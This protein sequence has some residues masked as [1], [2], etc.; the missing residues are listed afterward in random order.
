MRN[1]IQKDFIQNHYWGVINSY[2]QVFFS[3]DSILAYLLLLTTFIDPYVGLSGVFSILVG[4]IFVQWLGFPTHLVKDGTYGYNTLMIGLVLGVYYQFSIPFFVV[5]TLSCFF[6]VLLTIW[7]GNKASQQGVPF[8]SLPFLLTIWITILACRNYDALGLSTRGIY[9]INELWSFG[10]QHLVDFNQWMNTLPIPLFIDTYLKSLG[11]IF[12]QYNALSGLLICIG[13]LYASRISFSLSLLGFTVGY[14]FY[15]FLEGNITDLHY[16]YIGF[17]FILCAISLGGFFTIPSKKS[18]LLIIILTPIIAL[19]ISALGQVFGQLQLPL[20]SLPFNLIVILSIYILRLR[21]HTNGLDLIQEQSFSPEKNLYKFVN[22]KE[23]FA[24]D[25]YVHIHPPFFGKWFISQ[26]YNGGITH[27]GEWQDALDFVVVQENNQT[28][29]DPGLDVNHFHC[30][31]LPVLAPA[32]GTVVK[33]E[34]DIEDNPIGGVNLVKN[35]GNTII[36]Q[37]APTLYSKLSHIK[38]GTFTVK[39]GDYVEKG[40]V[41][42]NCGNS[43]RSPEP[44]IHFQLQTTPYIGSK[45][46]KYPL[47][48]YITQEGKQFN[49]HSFEIPLEEESIS[50]IVTSTLLKNAFAFIPGKTLKFKTLDPLEEKELEEEHH[51]DIIVDAYNQAYIYCEKTKSTAYF[52]N[53]GTLHYFTNFYGD[54]NSL[55]F[56]FYLAAHKIC[57]GYYHEMQLVDTLPISTFYHPQ[58]KFIQDFIA[59]FNI[60]L[61]NTYESQF[62]FIDDEH[63]PNQLKIK[64]MVQS[65]LGKKIQHQI[66]FEIIVENNLLKQFSFEKDNKLITAQCINEF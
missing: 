58:W 26:G 51:W 15:Y 40:T 63:F 65:K 3:N 12:F 47:S 13:L 45:T 4:N 25:T 56:Y 41:I 42:G 29:K 24:N 35:W 2:S 66:D 62:S 61:Q 30:Y 54:K 52:T 20:Y 5:L 11:A 60:F 1:Y 7:L 64:S 27:K 55:L 49:F 39:E 44:H 9:A 8:L 10:G 31:N 28:Y 36:I 14:L 17:N 33:V 46:L 19:L 18:Y 37:H 48:Y 43:G 38:K 34:D 22:Q 53:N 23:R 21:T 6:C 16:S 50:G 57:M 59:P 32:A